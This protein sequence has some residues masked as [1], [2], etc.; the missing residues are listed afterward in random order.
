MLRHVV[1]LALVSFPPSFHCH[2]SRGPA[3]KTPA[4]PLP[5]SRRL[6][7]QTWF[8]GASPLASLAPMSAPSQRR[9]HCP[10]TSRTRRCRTPSTTCSNQ[11]IATCPFS[12]SVAASVASI[13]PDLSRRHP[14]YGSRREIASVK[15]A[16]L[17]SSFGESLALATSPRFQLRGGCVSCYPLPC[18]ATPS[19]V[20]SLFPRPLRIL[21]EFQSAIL[22][23][24]PRLVAKEVPCY[25]RVPSTSS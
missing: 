10:R 9:R 16:T 7:R 15:G 4:R 12:P 5:P 3:L 6:S 18:S 2:S 14:W 22:N 23:H 17:V 21:I 20:S 11:P 1:H 24:Q 13:C 8:T 19:P 25:T